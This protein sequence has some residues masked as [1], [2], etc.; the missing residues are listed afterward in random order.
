MKDAH[1]VRIWLSKEAAENL[2]KIVGQT[3]KEGLAFAITRF[4][5]SHLEAQ[6]EEAAQVSES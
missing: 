6:N 2:G 5:D 4:I 1:R 3:D